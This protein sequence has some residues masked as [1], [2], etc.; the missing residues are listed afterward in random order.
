MQL[1]KRLQTLHQLG[2]RLL[3]E[4]DYYMAVAKRTAFD[5]PWFT[6]ANMQTAS[7]SIATQ[8]LDAAQLKEWSLHYQFPSEP[9]ARKV[10]LVPAGEMPFSGFQDLLCIL[11]VG[12]EAQIKLSDGDKY[13]LP[14]IAKLLKEQN[15]AFAKYIRFVDKLSDFDAA[16]V[17]STNE[18]MV[19]TYQRYFKA[20]PHIVRRL[21]RSV[22][23][24]SGAESEEQLGTLANDVFQYFGLGKRSVSK[25]FVPQGYDFTKLLEIFHQHNQLVLN[26]KYKNN[27]DYNTALLMMNQ[28]PYLSN[29]AIILKEDRALESRI[30]TLHYE[31]YESETALV[32]TL[33]AQQDEVECVVSTMPAVQAAMPVLDFGQTVRPSLFDYA[34]GTDTV[35]F[36]LQL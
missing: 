36:L 28:V 10:A 25:V 20:W 26:S 2:R 24:L 30:A 27:F 9:L 33:L 31:F 14:Y 4:D 17:T 8:L 23:V 22:A 34:G 29:G 19:N 21:R 11:A 16:I 18:K 3:E 13:L 6:E 15:E 12:H 35:N 1:D 32:N 7:R 5:N